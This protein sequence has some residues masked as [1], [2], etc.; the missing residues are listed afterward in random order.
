MKKQKF[1]VTGMTCSACSSHVEKSVGKLA[2]MEKVSVNLMTNS[3]QV[4]F[5]EN[6]CDEQI[7]IDAVEKAGYGVAPVAELHAS[8]WAG[9]KNVAGREAVK[10]KEQTKKCAQDL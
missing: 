1:D 10:G 3:M 5:D 9:E 7:I 8:S 4:T 6:L 2:G